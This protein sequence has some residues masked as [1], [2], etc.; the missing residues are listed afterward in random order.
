MFRLSSIEFSTELSAEAIG[1]RY[2]GLAW[3]IFNQDFAAMP[4]GASFNVSVVD[5]TLFSDGF[6]SGDTSVWSSTVP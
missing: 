5:P 2:T 4:L 3:S 1:V 6:E